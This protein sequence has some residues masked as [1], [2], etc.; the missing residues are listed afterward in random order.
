[1]TPGPAI[2]SAV[3]LGAGTMGAQIAAHLG[4][5]GIGNPDPNATMME[6]CVDDRASAK[7]CAYER[8]CSDHGDLSKPAA[9]NTSPPALLFLM[10]KQ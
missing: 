4:N 2:R 8:R 5:A 1:M 7:H 10:I 3:V 9:N 6:S